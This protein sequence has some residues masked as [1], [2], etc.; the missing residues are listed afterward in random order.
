MATILVI[1]DNNQIRALIRQAL[2]EAGHDVLDAS[3]GAMG[4]RCYREN[5]TDLV[6]TDLEM[7]VQ[8]GI[9]TIMQIKSA[10]PKSK[11]IGMS[12]SF[13]RDCSTPF[14][15]G[16]HGANAWLAKPFRMAEFVRTVTNLLGDKAGS[17]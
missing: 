17:N 8:G 6:V 15:A 7:P 12:G 9:E 11:I 14:S 1:D 2:E 13:T 4:V 3:D 10:N 16:Q 5:P